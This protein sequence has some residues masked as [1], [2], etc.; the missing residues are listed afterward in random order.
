MS[1][2]ESLI[3]VLLLNSGAG[4]LIGVDVSL[5]RDVFPRK[6][7][8]VSWGASGELLSWRGL[9]I[10]LQ[11][12]AEGRQETSSEVVVVA[13]WGDFALGIL[14]DQAGGVVRAQKAPRY[15]DG[16]AQARMASGELLKLID[17][18]DSRWMRKEGKES[19]C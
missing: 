10:P 7:A 19:S 3:E 9:S 5:V 2:A 17:I 11:G 1:E 18:E 16:E 6:K 15:V 12:L 14:V 13:G 4:E 8:E